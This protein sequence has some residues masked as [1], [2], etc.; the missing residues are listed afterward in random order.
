MKSILLYALLILS[1]AASAQG[2][3]FFHGSWEDAKELAS[4]EQKLI[5]V[6]A[7]AKW[8][9]PCK[10]MASQVFTNP[11]V[12]EYY[13]D[14]FINLKIDMEEGMG[15]TFRREYPVSAFPTLFYIDESGEIV[16]KVVGGKSAKDFI[17][18]GKSIV[19]SFDRSGDYAEKYD[20]GDR[21]YDLVLNYVK[22]LNQA[23]KSSLK[24]ANDYLRSNPDM[25][26]EQRAT[27][28]YESLTAVDSRIF[29]VY[30]D[31]LSSIEQTLG[32]VAAYDKIEAA[33]WNTVY[34]AIGFEV[35]DLLKEAQQKVAKYIPNKAEA[36]KIKSDFEYAQATNDLKNMASTAI[37][38]AKELLKDQ[39][40]EQFALVEELMLYQDLYP[41]I[42]NTA[43][44]IL[45]D[46]IDKSDDPAHRLLYAKVLLANDKKK[47]A[48]K[49]ANKAMKTVTEED[50]CYEE[51]EQFIQSLKA[52]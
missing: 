23:N 18:L 2:I 29:R 37:P 1:T 46:A 41:A 19:A 33:A 30:I 36:F 26:S 7:Y 45:S 6:D 40:E 34:S 48:S 47:K 38:Y 51:L 20:K 10:R 14:N 27:F 28:L 39:P 5:F 3:D 12:G 44:E 24:I 52:K 22:A 9:G 11:S 13:N 21:S 15:L 17:D 16:K 31:E 32:K 8:C 4:K 43:E 25:S 35:E 49:E 50:Q 42:A